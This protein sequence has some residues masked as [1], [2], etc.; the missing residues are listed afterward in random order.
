[1]KKQ[2]E[3]KKSSLGLLV[4]SS[5]PLGLTDAPSDKPG[6]GG[7]TMSP[8]RT[9]SDGS[10]VKH[11]VKTLKDISKLEDNSVTPLDSDEPQR[12]LQPRAPTGGTDWCRSCGPRTSGES[13]VIEMQE[14]LRQLD[15]QAK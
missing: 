6:H 9:M 5:M 15:E 10:Q 7:V 11:V 14:M 12:V 1:M 3:V 4:Q 2:H 13:E 8:T